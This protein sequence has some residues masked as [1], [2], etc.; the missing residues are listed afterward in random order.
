MKN[1]AIAAMFAFSI[2]A[3]NASGQTAS[4]EQAPQRIYPESN[5]KPDA[6]IRVSVQIS[7]IGLMRTLLVLTEDAKDLEKQIAQ[8]LTEVDFRVFPSAQILRGLPSSA[9]I[10]QIGMENKADLVFL[11][12][13][14]TRVKN[15]FGEFQ[16]NEGEATIQISSPASGELFVSRTS[17]G[18]GV[19]NVDPVEAERS[20]RERALDSATKDAIAKGLEKVHKMIVHVATITGVRDN[21]QLL[22]IKEHMAKMQGV[23]AVRQISFDPQTR[24]AQLE[25][26][27]APKG[28]EFWRAWLER[29][30]RA[31]VTVTLPAPRPPRDPS[32]YP[33]WF[34]PSAN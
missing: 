30:P 22:I 6:D 20:A 34:R 14:K 17:R 7:E 2:L 19:R 3:W 28:E 31:R 16:L 29:M 25:I 18:L 8:R 23:Y 33:S 32:S 12:D 27:G 21:N 11:A 1:T 10:R 24:V 5:P 4:P 26:I 13:V 9:E 15:K